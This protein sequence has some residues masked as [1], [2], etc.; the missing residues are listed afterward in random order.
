MSKRDKIKFSPKEKV[1]KQG[2]DKNF[3]I[4]SQALIIYS[5]IIKKCRYACWLLKSFPFYNGRER[6][7]CLE[8]VN[9]AMDK[10]SLFI[11]FGEHRNSDSIYVDSWISERAFNNVTINDKPEYAYEERV[12]THYEN[13][14]NTVKYIDKV[15]E[16]YLKTGKILNLKKPISNNKKKGS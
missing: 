2:F 7:I 3:D 9:D 4:K 5:I 13:Y 16:H 6:S 11:E 12:Y 15:I 14:T 8:V 10:N 1:V